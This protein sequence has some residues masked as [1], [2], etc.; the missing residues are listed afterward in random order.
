M[1]TG[2][3]WPI[4]EPNNDLRQWRLGEVM[5]GMTESAVQ[6]RITKQLNRYPLLHKPTGKRYQVA[7]EAGGMVELHQENGPATYASADAL[8]NTDVWELNE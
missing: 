2:G 1:L 3:R 8:K 4:I 5:P 6:R 7:Y